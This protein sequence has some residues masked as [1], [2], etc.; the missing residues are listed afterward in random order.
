MISTA[1]NIANLDEGRKDGPFWA[2]VRDGSVS[3]AAGL[4][5]PRSRPALAW[6]TATPHG[7]EPAAG[8]AI[9]PQPVRARGAHGLLERRRRM[10]DLD[11]FLLPVRNPD[12]RDAIIRTSAWSF[13]HNRDFGTQ[14]QIENGAFLPMLKQ[15]PGVFYIDAHQTGNGYFFPPNEDPVH[16]EISDFTVDFI[17]DLIG[18]AIR[19]S[20]NDQSIDYFNYDTYDLFVPEYGDTV[21]SLLSGAAGMTF[22]KG[23]SEIYGKQVYEHYLAIDSTVDVTAR[24]KAAVLQ[25][26]VSSGPRPCARARAATWSPNELVSPLTE[27]LKQQPV[28]RAC[29]ATS[30]AP[31]A[32]RATR[33]RWCSTCSARASTSTASSTTSTRTGVRE[34]GTGTSSNAALPK[35]TLYMPL[36]PAAQALDPGRDG[37]GP[38]RADR[39]LLRRRAPGRTRCTAASRARLPDHP[40]PARRADDA[41][42]AI[43]RWAR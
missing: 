27:P 14:N 36:E 41:R 33:R 35:G 5:R 32:T 26:W 1:D 15:Y 28:L 16:H 31:T 29:A 24:N 20:F 21:P 8:E 11:F 39:V 3:E 38:V 25:G 17:G 40:A 13:D 7:A 34:F 12:G 42:S 9:A 22:E 19:Q 43:P 37:R 30:S 18:P 6:I 23:T 2:G 4:P 10:Q